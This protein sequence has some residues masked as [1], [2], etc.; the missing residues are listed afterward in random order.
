MK[1]VLILATMLLA[2]SLF[3][4]QSVSAQTT[5]SLGLA[6]VLDG[7]GSIGDS[8]WNTMISGYQ[9][10]IQDPNV[11][12]QNG[13]VNLSAVQFSSSSDIEISMTPITSQS[14]ADAFATDL[15]NIN[16]A[17]GSTNISAGI[18]DG[19]NSLVNFDLSKDLDRWVI[20]VATDGQHNAGTPLPST[21]A[22]EVVNDT[23][24]VDAVNALGIGTGTAP[25]FNYGDN[26]FSMLTNNFQAFETAIKDK[27]GREV[28]PV[29]EPTT[30]LLL[31]TGLI[32]IAGIGRK[33][34]A[35]KG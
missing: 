33:K 8:E 17:G 27:I 12:P 23:P 1:R 11:L 28:N 13:K 15:G 10:A 22:Q 14:D 19:Y 21:K 4:I 30:W 29:P 26:S 34:F 5:K 6:L 3:C 16:Q 25:G 7:S 2:A 35:Q 9:N 20:D 31:A 24:S 32:G 18:E